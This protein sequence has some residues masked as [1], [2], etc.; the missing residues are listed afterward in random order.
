MWF[1]CVR[2]VLMRG[3]EVETLERLADGVSIGKAA[4]AAM[5]K[6][7]A[8]RGRM[9]STTTPTFDIWSLLWS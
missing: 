5:P 8:G 9:K 2:Q 7:A 3:T 6:K 1:P 4:F